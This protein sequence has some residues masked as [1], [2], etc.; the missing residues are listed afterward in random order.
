MK[1][2]IQPGKTITVP[3][4]ADVNSGEPVVIGSL[5]GIASVSALTGEDLTISREGVFSVVKVTGSAW[6]VGDKIYHKTGTTQ[7]TKTATSNTF[8]GIATAAAVSNA[9]TGEIVLTDA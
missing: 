5:K 8:F 6:A 9:E 2:Y 7:F 3:A 1:N 4:A